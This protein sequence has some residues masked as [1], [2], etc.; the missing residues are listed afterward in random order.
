MTTIF[1]D[2]EVTPISW[3][4][5]GAGEAVIFLH[6][7]VTSSTGWDPQMQVLAAD[8][9]CIAWDMPGFGRSTPPEKDAGF[10][11]VLQALVRF[12]TETLGLTKAH[13]VGL[14]VGG[15]IL[16]HLAVSHPALVRSMTLLDCSPK[17]GF[18]GNSNAAEFVAWVNSQL[19]SES[20]SAFNE[21]MIRAITA[22]IASRQ[23]IQSAIAAMGRAKRE[24]LEFAAHLIATHDALDLLPRI[25]CPTLVMAGALD[26]E[27]PPA[28][29]RAIAAGI[30]GANLSIIP[31][32]GHI[33]NLE[34]PEAVTDRLRVFL[35][36]GL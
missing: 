15:M 32:A 24:G 9:R 31:N 6:A 28:Y 26:S 33:A 3:R 27:T 34:A 8:Y 11:E 7:M 16:Q 21:S 20:Q 36:H 4:E 2:I 18:G 14:S 23:A 13:F 35:A 17:F 12:V 10:D 1:R 22:P 25:T 30:P 5:C 19:D 29:A